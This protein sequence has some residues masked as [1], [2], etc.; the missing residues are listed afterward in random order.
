[1]KSCWETKSMATAS[2]L[3]YLIISKYVDHLPLHRLEAIIARIGIEL[4]HQ[5]MAR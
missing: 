2:L 3:A 1:M 5:T 4:P